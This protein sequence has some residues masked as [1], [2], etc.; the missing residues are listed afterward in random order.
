MGFELVLIC[1]WGTHRVLLSVL[2]G[3]SSAKLA[4]TTLSLCKD[5]VVHCWNSLLQFKL[6]L[7][8]VQ[9]WG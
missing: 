8:D 9:H 6:A 5:L 4:K 3:S 7:G 1:F 2:Y